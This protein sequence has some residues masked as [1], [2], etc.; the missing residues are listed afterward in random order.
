MIPV[1]VENIEDIITHEICQVYT[2]KYGRTSR[3]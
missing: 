1:L 2:R 3:I